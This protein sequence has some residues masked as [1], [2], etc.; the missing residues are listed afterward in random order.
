MLKKNHFKY[1]YN[2]KM[3][4]ISI[5][6]SILLFFLSFLCLNKNLILFIF[7]FLLSIFLIFSSF[8]FL[9]GSGLK[10][11]SKK[12]KLFIRE[13]FLSYTFSLHE[14]I[15]IEIYPIKKEKGTFFKWLLKD[16]HKHSYTSETNYVYNNGAVFH[17]KIRFTYCTKIF[18]F[19]WMYKEKNENTVLKKTK[20][21]QHFIKTLNYEC[22]KARKYKK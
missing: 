1:D 14:I 2:N 17:I 18:Y 9:S 13:G 4:T 10:I 19:G 16:A 8:Y 3:T 20:E 22:N 6:I 21:L 15:N 7:L 11:D 12:G 5:I